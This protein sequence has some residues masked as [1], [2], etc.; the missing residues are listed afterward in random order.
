MVCVSRN[1][2]HMFPPFPGFIPD[3]YFRECL[4]TMGDRWSEDMVDDLFHGAPIKDGRLD[5]NEFTRTLKHGARGKDH[6]DQIPDIQ[7]DVTAPEAEVK[8]QQ[9]PPKTPPA[10]APK[11]AKK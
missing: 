4:M 8:D 11:P 5:Y 6:D 10:V 2:K 9:E 1:Y 7:P 3:E